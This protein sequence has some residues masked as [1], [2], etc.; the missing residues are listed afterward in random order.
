VNQ[1]QPLNQKNQPLSSVNQPLVQQNQPLVNQPLIQTPAT[2]QAAVGTL[3][4]GS[5]VNTA[6]GT[7]QNAGGFTVSIPAIGT[8]TTQGGA[9]SGTGG[10]GFFQGAAPT[11]TRTA[12]AAFAVQQG[13]VNF[14]A[15]TRN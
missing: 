6:P 9:F 8:L 13:I 15:T 7:V 4:N 1:N 5:W 2:N 14:Q 3:Y 12:S 11:Y 10:G